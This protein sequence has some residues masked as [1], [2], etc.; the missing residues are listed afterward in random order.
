MA[1]K[2]NMASVSL[3]LSAPD[4]YSKIVTLR[5]NG[6]DLRVDVATHFDQAASDAGNSPIEYNVYHFPMVDD[7]PLLTYAYG[8]LKGLPEKAAAVDV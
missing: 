2:Q 1:L 6:G 3:G 5:W 4:S 7:Q 8:Q